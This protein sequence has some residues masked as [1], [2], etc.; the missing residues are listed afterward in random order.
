MNEINIF[1]LFQVTY[2]N[3]KPA[4]Y[5]NRQFRIVCSEMSERFVSNEYEQTLTVIHPPQQQG[6]QQQ[7]QHP[8]DVISAR[9]EMPSH[10]HS[11][12]TDQSVDE[13]GFKTFAAR[14]VGAHSEL[15]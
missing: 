3:Q 8:R 4:Y 5:L 9:V 1:L 7:Q 10:A 6:Q 2:T 12:L 15:M 14:R 13:I 11:M